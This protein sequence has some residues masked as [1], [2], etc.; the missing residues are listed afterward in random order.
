M[1]CNEQESVVGLF[2]GFFFLYLFFFFFF[3]LSI[4]YVYAGICQDM[5]WTE[6]CL[7]MPG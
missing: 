4:I 3:F 1:L 6:D 5:G 7:I 2:G